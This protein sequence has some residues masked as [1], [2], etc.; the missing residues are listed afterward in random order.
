MNCD[1]STEKTVAGALSVA[2]AGVLFIANLPRT[3]SHNT[4]RNEAKKTD[5]DLDIIRGTLISDSH[6]SKVAELTA[7]YYYFLTAQ[8]ICNSIKI[9]ST[10]ISGNRAEIIMQSSVK[11]TVKSRSN[12]GQ[13][14]VRTAA[15]HCY[16]KA[17]AN[18]KIKQYMGN[19]YGAL[20]ILSLIHI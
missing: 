3:S 20:L 11:Y 4:R 16:V 9:W 17:G 2:G 14:A 5:L 12:V 7:K 19:N 1:Q 13:I 15:Y 6:A 10:F 18:Y 8:V